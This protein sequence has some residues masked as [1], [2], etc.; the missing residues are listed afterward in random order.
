MIEAQINELLERPD[1][2]EIIRD[3]IAA[4][5]SLELQNQ[6]ALAEKHGKNKS[7]FDIKVYNENARPYDNTSGERLYSI[8]V[9]LQEIKVPLSN[10]RIHDQKEIATFHIYCIADGNNT[11]DFRDDRSA[12]FRAWKLMRFVRRI[13]MSEQYTY[14]DMRKLVTSRTFTKMEAGS[15][16]LVAAN[17]ITVIKASFEVQFIEFLTIQEASTFVGYDFTINPDDGEV[18]AKP[19]KQSLIDRITGTDKANNEE[20]Q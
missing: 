10:S 1:T 6:S 9:V 12:T 14:L 20:G 19:T 17:A 13:L 8:N 2:V 16:G 15:P 7:D 4:I 11:G 3:Q 18:T 5:L